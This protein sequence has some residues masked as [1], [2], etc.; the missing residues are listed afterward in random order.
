M[1]DLNVIY[2]Y[3]E[4][5]KIPKWLIVKPCTNSFDW[6]ATT[7]FI[8]LDQ[9]F[10]EI[11]QE[12]INDDILGLSILDTDLVTNIEMP[13]SIGIYIPRVLKRINIMR[14]EPGVPSFKLANIEQIIINI[15]DLQK[16]LS[17]VSLP[18]LSAEWDRCSDF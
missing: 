9:T 2:Q 12:E 1:F 13:H 3:A 17:L 15:P 14:G 16:A 8:P 18:I 11:T 5:F 10:S 6:K 7:V 4:G